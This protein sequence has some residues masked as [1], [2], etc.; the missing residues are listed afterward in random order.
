MQSTKLYMDCNDQDASNGQ[1]TTFFI[2]S[3]TD[4]QHVRS[5][6]NYSGRDHSASM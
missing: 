4:E 3:V 6:K 2:R 1:R 5:R